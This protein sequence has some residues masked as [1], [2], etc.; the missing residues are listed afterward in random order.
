MTRP[1]TFTVIFRACDKVTAVNQNPRP[2]GLNKTELVKLCFTSLERALAAVPHE[3]IVVG[4]ALSDELAHFFSTRSVRLISGTFGNDNSIRKTLEIACQVPEDNWIYF[5]EDDYLHTPDALAKATDF[6]VE[7]DSILKQ[8]PKIY[9]PSSWLSL[10]N[11]HLFLFLPDY[12]D[13]YLPKYRKHALVVTTSSSHWRQ[14]SHVTFSFITRGASVRKFYPMMHGAAHQANDRRLSRQLF[15]RLG[16]GVF[17]PAICFSPVPGLA[18]H[19]HRDTMTP[20]VNWQ[21]LLTET[22]AALNASAAHVS[23]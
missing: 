1:V 9:N 12:P 15:G 16:Y 8:V 13:R 23:A 4:D 2:F 5:C 6:I 7:K 18:T 17:S 11:K 22:R 20:L 19:M 10:H 3:V 21:A 14:V